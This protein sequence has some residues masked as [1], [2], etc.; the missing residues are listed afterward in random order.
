MS[1]YLVEFTSDTLYL[2]GHEVKARIVSIRS[3]ASG[4][5]TQVDTRSG[6]N[7]CIALTMSHEGS[8]ISAYRIVSIM[9]APDD[10]TIV[11]LE[12]VCL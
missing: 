1:L 4:A 2:F 12:E 7:R 9:S 10:I 11:R 8:G 5:M 6:Y 3:I